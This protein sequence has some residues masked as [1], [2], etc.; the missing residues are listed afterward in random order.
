MSKYGDWL[1]MSIRLKTLKE[2]EMRTR[3]ELCIEIFEGRA[4]AE[5]KKFEADG[6]K[7]IAENAIGHKIDEA[8]LKAMWEELTETE[9]ES[10]AWKPALKLAN[11]K[12]LPADKLIHECITSKPSA[13]TLKVTKI[14]E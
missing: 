6:F 9:T 8:S 10:I 2:K 12:K 1:D 7:I 3:K 13:P 14:E 4:G 5:K 11:Y